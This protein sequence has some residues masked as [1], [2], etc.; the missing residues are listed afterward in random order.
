MKKMPEMMKSGLVST[1]Q[2][3]RQVGNSPKS[4]QL[5][6]PTPSPSSPVSVKPVSA[7]TG[8]SVTGSCVEEMIPPVSST[9]T[10]SMVRKSRMNLPKTAS[11][12]ETTG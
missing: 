7:D 9:P 1:F 10:T 3:L 4:T 12:G 5:I 2:M 11:S 6:V 8:S